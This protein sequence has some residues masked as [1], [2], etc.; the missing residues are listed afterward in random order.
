MHRHICG[1]SPYSDMKLLLTRNK[2]WNEDVERYL[3]ETVEKSPEIRPTCWPQSTR[4]VSLSS[5][6]R[7][8]DGLVCIGHFYM[9]HLCLLHITDSVMRYSSCAIDCSVC[10]PDAVL[11]FESCWLRKFWPRTAVLG[12]P[13]FS[14]GK[15]FQ[16]LSSL[17]IEAKSIPPHRH[18]KNVLES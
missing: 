17:F 13:T 2:F 12:D 8:F 7:S 4:K 16:Y 10:M 1:H 3:N 6:S 9:A 14:N 15:F 11:A 18:N 5:L